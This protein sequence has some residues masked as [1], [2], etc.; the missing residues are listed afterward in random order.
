MSNSQESQS[1]EECNF[2]A[3]ALSF[4]GSQRQVGRRGGQRG[5][6]PG[7][8]LF[9]WKKMRFQQAQN[10][11]L[12]QLLLTCLAPRA[13]HLKMP[14]I[15]CSYGNNAQGESRALEGRR[16]SYKS[17]SRLQNIYERVDGMNKRE[18]YSS[19]YGIIFYLSCHPNI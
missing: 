8:P 16:V 15:L 5:P 2:L 3:K 13:A 6:G 9:F 18:Q 17:P 7:P 4:R 11:G 10:K 19:R 14:L 1:R 12:H